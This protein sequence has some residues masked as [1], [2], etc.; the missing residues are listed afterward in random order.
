[1]PKKARLKSVRKGNNLKALVQCQKKEM[2]RLDQ[3]TKKTNLSICR[4]T[5]KS[6]LY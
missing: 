6:K 1:M 4:K 5:G 3:L 2:A